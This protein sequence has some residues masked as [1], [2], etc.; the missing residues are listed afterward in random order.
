M[1]QR[2]VGEQVYYPATR[3]EG[4]LDIVALARGVGRRKA[5]V[6]LPTILAAAASF[7]IV[8]ALT[9][10][11]RSEAR[12]LVENQAS[13]F[14][15]PEIEK[16]TNGADRERLDQ[17]AVASQAQILTSRDLGRTVVRDLKLT[18]KTEFDPLKKSFS[19]LTVLTGLLGIGRDY[20]KIAPEDRA[21]EIY[22]DRLKAAPVEKSR[23]VAVSFTSESADLAANIVN[24]VSENFL[25]LQTAAKRE[26]NHVASQWLAGEIDQLRSKVSDAEAKVSEFRTK[27]NLYI[28]TNNNLLPSQMLGE[29][30]TQLV[31]ARAQKAEWEARSNSIRDMLKA[32][33]PPEASEVLNS[34]LMRRLSEQ[35]VTLRAQLAEQ[36]STLL[37]GHPRIKELKAQLADLEAHMRSEAEK[38]AR[39]FEN[40]ARISAARVEQLKATMEQMKQQASQANGQDVELRALEREAKAQRDL[41]ESYL[42]RY[43]DATAREDAN[44]MPPDARVI[45]RAFPASTP[46]FPRKIPIVIIATLA[47]F[48]LCVS[49]VAAIALFGDDVY[50]SAGGGAVEMAQPAQVA[51]SGASVEPLV[52][53]VATAPARPNAN[54][55]ILRHA[56]TLRGQGKTST[57]VVPLVPGASV[58]GVALALARSLASG[59]TRSLLVDLGGEGFG[60][61]ALTPD[62][63]PGI[64]ELLRGETNFGGVIHRDGAT[65]LH[66]VPRGENPETPEEALSSEKFSVA[67]AALERSY[68]QIVI[69]ADLDVLDGGLE[70]LSVYAENLM[71]VVEADTI[72]DAAMAASRQFA[73]L[74]FGSVMMLPIGQTKAVAA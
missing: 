72:D 20:E 55:L 22:L 28:G 39:A 17:E 63:R 10:T 44:A 66:L 59:S 11:Y 49:L 74:G 25:A 2:Q 53:R 34:E 67:Y 57:A 15:K 46:D 42:S 31:T 52:A 14:M 65:R 70:L 4:E 62:D 54:P 61:V 56:A 7:F 16:G 6:I 38:I 23:V 41:L 45:S 43:R 58:Q 5:W 40:D 1:V 69:S 27:A 13:T 37:D 68:D 35:R 29:L 18:D 36:R 51:A 8:N 30:N 9:P 47:T 19:P 73:E 21:L 26:Q 33:R 32:G 60:R 12:L 50:R 64:G 24:K 71:V 48:I 3:G